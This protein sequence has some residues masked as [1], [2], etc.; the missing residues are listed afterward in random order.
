MRSCVDVGAKIC[1]TMAEANIGHLR[2]GRES[3]ELSCSEDLR[4]IQDPTAHVARV[5][6]LLVECARFLTT[7][8]ST[9]VGP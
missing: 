1:A 2:F 3:T 4:E 8:S 7:G 6:D 9:R 5:I